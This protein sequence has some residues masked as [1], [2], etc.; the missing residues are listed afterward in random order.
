MRN[1]GKMEG[2]AGCPNINSFATPDFA[3]MYPEYRRGGKPASIF[4]KCDFNLNS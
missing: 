1:L 3:Q 2:G 4:P